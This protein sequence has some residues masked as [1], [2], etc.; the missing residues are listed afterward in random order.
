MK[1][2][3]IV[4]SMALMLAAGITAEASAKPGQKKPHPENHGK[5]VSQAARSKSHGHAKHKSKDY[6]DYDDR[7]DD[8]Y[9]ERRDSERRYRDSRDDTWIRRRPTSEPT[10]YRRTTRTRQLSPAQ[11]RVQRENAIQAAQRRYRET[12]RRIIQDGSPNNKL[13]RSQLEQLRDARRTRDAA[14]RAA[15]RRYETQLRR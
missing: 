4:A 3:W 15:K 9:R 6:D 12:R 11:A 2:K 1:N 10:R 8:R 5:Y 14:I 13:T 7:D